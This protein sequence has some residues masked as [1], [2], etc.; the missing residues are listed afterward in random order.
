MTPLKGSSKAERKTQSTLPKR[1]NTKVV[2]LAQNPLPLS[3]RASTR[4]GRRRLPGKHQSALVV[5]FVLKF[6]DCPTCAGLT[7]KAH[8]GDRPKV[9]RFLRAVLL[10]HGGGAY[11]INLFK[12]RFVAMVK[13]ALLFVCCG[14]LLFT[15]LFF[16]NTQTRHGSSPENRPRSVHFSISHNSDD[17]G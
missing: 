3:R 8:G 1:S 11:S 4:S 14:W 12:Y 5:L 16:K 10:S 6:V 13:P 9:H 7:S 2:G 15:R 17:C